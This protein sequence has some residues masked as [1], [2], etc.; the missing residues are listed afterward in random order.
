MFS[1]S[2]EAIRS[3][4]PGI[5]HGGVGHTDGQHDRVERHRVEQV[6]QRFEEVGAVVVSE[7]QK[8]RVRLEGALAVEQASKVSPTDESAPESV[9]SPVR[10]PIASM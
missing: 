1:W 3:G 5:E 8:V 2:A 9:S 4:W 7:L 6:D 10:S